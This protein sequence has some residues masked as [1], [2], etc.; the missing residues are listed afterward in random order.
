VLTVLS[1]SWMATTIEVVFAG[2]MLSKEPWG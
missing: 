1:S 2:S